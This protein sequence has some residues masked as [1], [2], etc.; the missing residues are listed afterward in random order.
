M[1]RKATFAPTP[2]ILTENA[3]YRVVTPP[4]RAKASSGVGSQLTATATIAIGLLAT[5]CA[6][7][8]G[9]AHTLV[10]G[11]AV[12]ERVLQSGGIDA[13]IAYR[14]ATLAFGLALMCTGISMAGI[15]TRSRAS[16]R[17][18]PLGLQAVAAGLVATNLAAIAW[19]T[20]WL[21]V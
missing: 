5:L 14:A 21:F 2:N 16:M 15:A 17:R 19:W 4:S 12:A 7:A 13:L 10:A 8:S 9:D 3:E 20:A 11:N 1:M 6:V 18:A